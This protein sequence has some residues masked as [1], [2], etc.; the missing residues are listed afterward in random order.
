M[1]LEELYCEKRMKFNPCIVIP[2]FNHGELIQNTIDSLNQYSLPIL[3]IDDGSDQK[4]KMVLEDINKN[5]Q[6]VCVETLANNIGKGGAVIKGIQLAEEKKFTHALQIDAD[7][8]HDVNDI[9]KMLQEAKKFPERMISGCPIYNESVPKARFYGRYVTHVWVWIETL[10][11]EIKDSMCGF[12]IY[13]VESCIELFRNYKLG[14]RMDF[15]TEVMVKF[16]WSGGKFKFLPT[17]VIYP[18]YGISHFD[19]WRDNWRQTKMHT[20]LFFGMLIRLPYLLKR[21]LLKRKFRKAQ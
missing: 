19:V 14:Q 5:I 21:N 9:P 16:F 2:I 12:R 13:P 15:D 3:I 1:L 11:L 20:R 18:E 6:N 17:K 8:H 4:T 10:S 7:G